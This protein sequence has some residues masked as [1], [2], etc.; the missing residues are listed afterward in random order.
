MMA[1]ID[2]AAAIIPLLTLHS[3][4][5]LSHDSST[6]SGFG[7]PRMTATHLSQKERLSYVP[8]ILG[9]FHAAP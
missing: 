5:T 1:A 9:L 8:L 2:E 3:K 4:Q 7:S 6:V